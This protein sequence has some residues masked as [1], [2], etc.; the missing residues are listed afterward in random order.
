MT[1]ENIKE[2]ADLINGNWHGCKKR[3]LGLELYATFNDSE[4]QDIVAECVTNGGSN[5]VNNLVELL[6]KDGELLKSDIMKN[7]DFKL[8]TRGQRSKLA[9]GL[10]HIPELFVWASNAIEK[11]KL[12]KILEDRF[13]EVFYRYWNNNNY[14]ENQDKKTY[15]PK[16]TNEADNL[17]VISKKLGI[18]INPE[19]ILTDLCKGVM[20]DNYYG[21]VLDASKETKFLEG[22]KSYYKIGKNFNLGKIFINN[23]TSRLKDVLKCFQSLNKSLASKELL[24]STIERYGDIYLLNTLA[25]RNKKM[26]VKVLNKISAETLYRSFS[27]FHNNSNLFRDLTKEETNKILTKILKGAKLCK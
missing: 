26:F 23:D 8:L 12:Q 13:L 14:Y 18:K 20:P 4:R 19:K 25:R 27:E 2:V 16:T 10:V 9:T 15:A 21:C 5:K 7:F 3:A 11:D 6:G 22:F 24:N 17:E 1:N